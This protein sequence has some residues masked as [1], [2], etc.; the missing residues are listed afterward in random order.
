MVVA[1]FAARVLSLVGAGEPYRPVSP[2]EYV[3]DR[4]Y[5]TDQSSGSGGRNLTPRSSGCISSV[6]VFQCVTCVAFRIY[7]P[8]EGRF[9]A[10]YS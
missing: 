5:G 9:F 7:S 3:A 6:R 1:V 8:T 4:P 2:A 10:Q